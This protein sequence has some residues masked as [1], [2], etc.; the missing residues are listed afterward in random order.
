VSVGRPRQGECG[1]SQRETPRLGC[2]M[3]WKTFP[4][5]VVVGPVL[6]LKQFGVGLIL[7]ISQFLY[8]YRI[9]QS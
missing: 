5:F 7:E 3:K 4:V 8:G 2:A 1:G 9:V 6:K